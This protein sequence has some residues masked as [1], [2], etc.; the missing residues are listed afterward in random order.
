MFCLNFLISGL[1]CLLAISNLATG[2]LYYEIYT[3]IDV[4]SVGLNL[5]V[6]SKAPKSREGV[7]CLV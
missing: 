6:W 2:K 5:L 4:A 3:V 7:S 1:S